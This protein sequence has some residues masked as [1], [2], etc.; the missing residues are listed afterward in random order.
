MDNDTKDRL[1]FIAKLLLKAA[2][3]SN[4][5]LAAEQID[6]AWANL[7]VLHEQLDNGDI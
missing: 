7:S 1:R 6:D 4:K 5:D 3:T 2:D